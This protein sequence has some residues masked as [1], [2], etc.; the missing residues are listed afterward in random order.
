MT[1]DSILIWGAGAVGGTLGAYLARAGHPVVLVDRNARHVAAI[2]ADGLRMSGPDGDDFTVHPAA[3]LPEEVEGRF[4]TVFVAVKAHQTDEAAHAL[5]PHLKDE[6]AVVSWQNGL[7]ELQLAEVVGRTK[8]IGAFINF[9][10]DITG[11]GALM[12]GNRGAVVL[13][14]LDGEPRPRT[15]ALHALLTD[16][17]PDAIVTD[18]IW[19]YLWGKLAYSAILKA[20]ALSTEPLIGFIADPALR[21]LHVAL[22]TEIVT[23]AQ[24]AG[25][26]PLG[27]NGFEPFVFA[28]G[29]RRGIDRSIAA[30]EQF[31]RA[32]AKT[33]SATWQDLA[34]FKQKSD[35]SAQLAPVFEIAES[36]GIPMPYNRKMVEL[37]EAVEAGVAVQ[38]D[39]LVRQLCQA[40]GT[41]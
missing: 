21:D 7:C 33:H 39:K 20:S 25:V 5:L 36:K 14:E 34:I 30:M 9:G 15:E 6:A 26:T 8:V 37:I 10:A 1:E 24:A 19:G 35:T 27:F 2:N 18:N 17:E 11:P 41:S 16:F 12:M 29:D 32:S 22:V 28:R 13:G 31:N 3:R 40:G 23:V 38:G 4:S